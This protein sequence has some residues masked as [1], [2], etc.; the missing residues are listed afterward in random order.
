MSRF[1]V[2]VGAKRYESFDWYEN[3]VTGARYRARVD[4]WPMAQV[5]HEPTGNLANVRPLPVEW[6]QSYD[7]DLS[8]FDPIVVEWT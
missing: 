8:V 3:A 2:Y 5:V 4:G 6:A 1:V 7:R